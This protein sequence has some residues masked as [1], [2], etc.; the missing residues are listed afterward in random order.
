M[1]Q[2]P[3][4]GYWHLWADAQ[5]VS[6]QTRCSIE[7]FVLESIQPGTAPQ[8]QG[9]KLMGCMT[10]LVTVLPIGWIGKWHE[11]PRPQWIIPLTGRWF[12]EAMD[13]CRTEMGPG[14]LAFGGDQNCTEIDGKRGHQSGT[15]GTEP[16]VLLIVQFDNDGVPEP[17]G[18]R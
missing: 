17:C 12:V 4:I 18:F 3:K 1:T 8:W 9:R 16:A 10:T 15:V 14:E 11:N 6:H 13:G 5:G 2:K 7:E